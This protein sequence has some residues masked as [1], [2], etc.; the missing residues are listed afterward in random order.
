MDAR[1]AQAQWAYTAA[2]WPLELWRTARLFRVARRE[3]LTTV[4]RTPALLAAGGLQALPGAA[5]AYAARSALS[6]RRLGRVLA[7]GVAL[8]ALAAHAEQDARYSGAAAARRGAAGGSAARARALLRD[9]VVAPR[10]HHAAL[11]SALLLRGLAW[12]ALCLALAWLGTR[13]TGPALTPG[14]YRVY[15]GVA[16]TL[17]ALAVLGALA[18]SYSTLRALGAAIDA[19]GCVPAQALAAAEA[20]EAGQAG[21]VAT[22]AAAAATVALNPLAGATAGEPVEWAA[23]RA[24]QQQPPAAA[25]QQQS[26]AEAVAALGASVP[27]AE[28]PQRCAAALADLHAVRD[29]ARARALGEAAVLAV[30]AGGGAGAVAF[31]LT[32]TTKAQ[33]R[34]F[35]GGAFA[36]AWVLGLAP[37]LAGARGVVEAQLALAEAA[38]VAAAGLGLGGYIAAAPL[39]SARGLARAALCPWRAMRASPAAP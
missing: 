38:R 21:P 29:R 33:F 4:L 6:Q 22:A 35:T 17:L 11:T 25:L 7:T 13:P 16:C 24:P 14:S 1:A 15:L 26:F 30:L 10:L 36:A 34:W 2:A 32:A 28:L 8:E 18:Q 3:A 9:E 37:A 39:C 31:A 19:L 12:G 23:P 27:R 5:A 20:A